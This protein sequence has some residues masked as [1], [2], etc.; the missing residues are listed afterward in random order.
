MNKNINK[1][2]IIIIKGA[3]G[4]VKKAKHKVTGLYRAVKIIKKAGLSPAEEM[5]LK[6]EIEILKNLVNF[7]KYKKYTNFFHLYQIFFF[8]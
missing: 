2:Y 1:P 8:F 6:N 5:E 3:Y 7:K 4:Q